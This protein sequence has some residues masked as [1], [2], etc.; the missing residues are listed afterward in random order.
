MTRAVYRYAL[1]LSPSGPLRTFGSQWLGRDADT[2]ATLP[3]ATDMPA[4][5]ADW[6]RAPAHYGLMQVVRISVFVQPAA[7]E[8]FVV[9]RDYGFDGSIADGAGAAYLGA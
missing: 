3:P 9:A 4:V 5:P 7:G 1:Y 6:V 2:G 8:D